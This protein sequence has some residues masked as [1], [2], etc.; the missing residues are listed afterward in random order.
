MIRAFLALEVPAHIRSQLV[1]QQYLLPVDRKVPPENFHIT[2]V[3]LGDSPLDRLEELHLALD[4]VRVPEM[5][6][7][8]KGLGLFGKDKPHNL[9]AVVT[10]DEG[11]SR[12]QA[13]LLTLAR[14]CGFQLTPRRFSPHV[15]LSYLRDGSFDRRELEMAVVRDAQFATDPFDVQEVA[16]FRSVLRPDGAVHDVLER[17]GPEHR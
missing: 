17:Y 11:L 4:K 3:F 5:R 1:L 9:H 7:R 14:N 8:I 13:K 10:P 12:F 2:L 6:L 15:T 16:L